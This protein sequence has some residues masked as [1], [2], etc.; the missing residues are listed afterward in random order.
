MLHVVIDVKRLLHARCLMHV[1]IILAE[2]MLF[3]SQIPQQMILSLNHSCLVPLAHL[4]KV[5]NT[6]FLGHTSVKTCQRVMG[7]I[8]VFKASRGAYTSKAGFDEHTTTQHS[9]TDP[10]ADQLKGAWFCIRNVCWI[11][12]KNLKKCLAVTH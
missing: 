6:K 7:S 2:I 3:F 5:Q 1:F 9:V 11:L 4:K 8:D 12:R 10:L